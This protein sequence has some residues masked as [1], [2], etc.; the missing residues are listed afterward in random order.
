V[1]GHDDVAQYVEFVAKTDSFESL[2]KE[3]SGGWGFEVRRELMTTE[4]YQVKVAGVLIP[5]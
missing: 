2:F 5:D 3:G 4:G 1:L